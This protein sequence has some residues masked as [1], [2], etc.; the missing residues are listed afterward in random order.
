MKQI[1]ELEVTDNK[2]LVLSIGEFRGVERV[3][4]R[5]Y[6]KAKEEFIPTPKGINFSAEWID[7]FVEMVEKL[8]D[9]D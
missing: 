6:V 7:D 8:K 9:I 3:D 1:A 5:Q 4:L 2:K